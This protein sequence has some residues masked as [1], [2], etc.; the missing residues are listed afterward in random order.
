MCNNSIF[1]WQ[2]LEHS[3]IKG[4]SAGIILICWI[5]WLWVFLWYHLVFSKYYTYDLFLLRD[6]YTE[7]SV[8]ASLFH[9]CVGVQYQYSRLG[10]VYEPV[11]LLYREW[12]NSL[13]IWVGN[14]LLHPTITKRTRKNTITL[15]HTA[16]PRVSGGLYMLFC[17]IATSTV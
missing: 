10:L 9:T 12:C 3:F 16:I 5:C 1:R 4:P 8:S 6:F 14:K 13:L 2:L 15:Y 7:I 17:A 11:V